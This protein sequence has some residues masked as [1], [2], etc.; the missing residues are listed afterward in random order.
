MVLSQNLVLQDTDLVSPPGYDTWN[1]VVSNLVL[2][3]TNLVSS[4]GYETWNGVVPKP[5]VAG[6]RPCVSSW[7]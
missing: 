2:Q 5:S 6:Y 3:D 7:V 1:G 4:P